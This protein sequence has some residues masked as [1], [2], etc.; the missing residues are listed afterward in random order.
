[1][2]LPEQSAVYG[3]RCV[4]TNETYIGAS[5]RPRDRWRGHQTECRAGRNQCRRLQR[6]W[7]EYGPEAFEHFII[8]ECRPCELEKLEQWYI[9][10]LGPELNLAIDLTHCVNGHP[11]DDSNNYKDPKGWRRC[12][13]CAREREA[14]KLKEETP[15]KRAK[16]LTDGKRRYYANKEKGPTP[17]Q[18]EKRLMWRR[19]YH[20]ANRERLNAQ[21]RASRSRR[22]FM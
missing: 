1:M 20:A 3:I 9:R 15:E 12:R 10:V 5:I 14:T 2:P 16:R 6:A 19:A 17:E 4:L 22:R 7:N 11:Y 13:V 18:H 21:L 8:E